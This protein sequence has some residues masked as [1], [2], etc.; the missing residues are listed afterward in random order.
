MTM[1]RIAAAPFPP[2]ASVDAAVALFRSLSDAARLA[3]VRRLAGGEARVADLV[4]ELGLAQSTV[5]ERV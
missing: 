1:N 3:I 2:E 4:S 5:S